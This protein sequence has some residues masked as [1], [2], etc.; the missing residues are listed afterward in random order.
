MLTF[1]QMLDDEVAE[2]MLRSLDPAVATQLR[3]C[4]SE[5]TRRSSSAKM[6]R[7][8]LDE[9][10]RFFHFALKYSAP[11]LK[12]HNP[13]KAGE[14]DTDYELTG[15]TIDD[16]EQMNV[17]QLTSALEEESA[18]TGAI[19]MKEL[20]AERNAEIL[21]LMRHDL[22]D[23]VVLE[24]S[25]NPKAPAILV[26]QVARTTLERALS[27]P[28]ER[29]EEPDPVQRIAEVLR[30]TQKPMRRGML[31]S[32]QTQDPEMAHRIQKLLYRFED[33]IDLDDVQVRSVLGKVETSTISTALFGCDEA[34]MDKVMSNLSKRARL[35]L[36]E[37]LSFLSRVP[38]SQLM[39]AR[40]TV[41]DAIAEVEMEGE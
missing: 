25:R 9:F 35:T 13:N 20:S 7:R 28:A 23:A 18:R 41:T 8:V 40:E 22:R 17:Y 19:L 39:Q 2:H 33:L 15:D 24:L 26:Q 3:Q 10:D 37:E 31:K 32:F 16:L 14:A 4:L 6:Q 5:S 27:L 21:S 1:L 29:P 38:E 12:V 34:I 11:T 36:E 30:A